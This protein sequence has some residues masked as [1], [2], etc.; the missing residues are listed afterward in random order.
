VSRTE[1]ARGSSLTRSLQDKNDE[2]GAEEIF[3]LI[4]EAYQVLND[5]NKRSTYDKLRT[6][7][8][9]VVPATHNV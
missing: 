1:P 8:V 6:E 4:N 2:P 3:K 7:V 9:I 5:E